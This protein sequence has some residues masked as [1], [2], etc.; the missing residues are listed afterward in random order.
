MFKFRCT[1]CINIRNLIY[2]VYHLIYQVYQIYLLIY[3]VYQENVT[4]GFN[5]PDSSIYKL[6][7]HGISGDVLRLLKQRVVLNSQCS[8]KRVSWTYS[9]PCKHLRWSFFENTYVFHPSTIFTKCSIL[10]VWQGSEYAP[11]CQVS[12]LGPFIFLI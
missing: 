3:K 9:E 1:Q 11:G 10:Y 8:L 5:R 7:N 6:K 12:V 2:Q 4:I